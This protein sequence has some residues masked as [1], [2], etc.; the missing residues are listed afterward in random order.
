MTYADKFPRDSIFGK[1]S[2]SCADL[3]FRVVVVLVTGD[4]SDG[5][6][7]SKWG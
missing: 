2:Y 1:H 7:L 3:R 5:Y 6:I 4:Q